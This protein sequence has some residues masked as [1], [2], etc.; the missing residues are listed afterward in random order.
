M[1][2]IVAGSMRR[3][4]SNYDKPEW[5]SVDNLS[6]KKYIN[7]LANRYVKTERKK[8]NI[9]SVK[10]VLDKIHRAFLSTNGIDPL[11]GIPMESSLISICKIVESG[12][13][14]GHEKVL[15]R[16]PTVAVDTNEK[17]R[18][19]IVISNQSLKAKGEMNVV[20]F[21]QYCTGIADYQR[22]KLSQ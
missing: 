8:G 6:Y 14:I 15:R 19:F 1:E 11:D 16:L 7:K 9:Y 10:E 2:L 13:L 22:N 5:I 20:E 17:K 3:G 4:S 18:E 21:I 12:Q